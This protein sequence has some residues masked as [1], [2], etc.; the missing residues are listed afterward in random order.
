M[1][2]GA[3]KPAD[4]T[5][6]LRVLFPGVRLSTRGNGPGQFTIRIPQTSALHMGLAPGQDNRPAASWIARQLGQPVEITGV[7]YSRKTDRW[8]IT[9]IVILRQHHRPPLLPPVGCRRRLL[10]PGR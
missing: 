10:P 9:A 7:T 2:P 4:I 1:P 5:R 8:G 3:V 6:A